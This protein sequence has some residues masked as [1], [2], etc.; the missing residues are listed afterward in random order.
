MSIGGAARYEDWQTLAVDR[1][2]LVGEDASPIGT[3]DKLEAHRAPGL[4]HLA[5]SV[6]I[7][8]D[9][10]RLLLQQ[11][12]PGKYHFGGRWS[13]TCCTHPKPGEEAADAARRRL[14]EEMGIDADLRLAG[15][16]SYRAED[17]VSGLVENEVDHVLVGE[18]QGDPDANPDEVSGWRWVTL[19]DLATDLDRSPSAYTPWLVPGLAL[20][21]G[22]RYTTHS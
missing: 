5:I 21:A 16:F 4:L 1:V 20:A 18:H 19:E 17:P 22:G 3:A 9:Q 13:N 6:F 14:W 2:V 8:D 11:R 10:E 7:F 12:S 15:I